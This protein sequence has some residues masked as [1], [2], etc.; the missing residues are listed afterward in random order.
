MSKPL[1]L[2]IL[3]TGTMAQ[4]FAVAVRDVDGVSLAGF[5]SRDL[6][7]AR[8]MA[9]Y[10]GATRGYAG[11][12]ELLADAAVD[13]L[14]IANDTAAHAAA[15][16]AALE[17]RKAVLCEKP[18][19]IDAAQAERIAVAAASAGTLF[20]EAVPTPFL[21][22]VA[23]TLDA[24]RN[25]TLGELRRFTASFGYPATPQSHPGC[26][27]TDGGGGVL[28]DRGI[29]LATLALLFM[30][31]AVDVRASITRNADGVDIEAWMSLTHANGAT[32][33]LDCSLTGELENRLAVTGTKGRATV[34]A[35]L[36][37]GE[38][39]EVA[40]YGVPQRP[41]PPGGG[42]AS[43]LKQKP[44]LRKAL[45]VLR[46]A[47]RPQLAFGDSLYR[48]EIEHFRDLWLAGATTSPVLPPS[49]SIAALA[50]LDRARSASR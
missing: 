8:T 12:G 21:P 50:I 10:Y 6:Q 1:R 20:M 7:R 22:A 16:I 3:G 26:F 46:A 35:P 37:A 5:L 2:A 28:L 40:T 24:A 19:G 13:A 15:A 48:G 43:R 31:P 4:T 29:Y 11:L 30:G 14:Y 44:A 17:A 9:T 45:A 36:L 27:A 23:S 39:F 34:D 38:R 18:C 42:L 47:R 41:S 49:Q 33:Q 32:S 25:G